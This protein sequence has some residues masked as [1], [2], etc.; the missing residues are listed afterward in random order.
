M[1]SGTAWLVLALAGPPAVLAEEPGA[2]ARSEVAAGDHLS[3]DLGLA[4]PI[5]AEEAMVFP[6]VN[7]VWAF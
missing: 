5:A 3:A 6:V 1:T 2:P 4:A 7:V